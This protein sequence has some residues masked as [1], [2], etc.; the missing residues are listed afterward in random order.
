[1]DSR[2]SV[3]SFQ[4]DSSEAKGFQEAEEFP[5]L[6]VA[7]RIRA[8]QNKRAARERAALG[9]EVRYFMIV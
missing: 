4:P 9:I 2:Y 6:T 1:L 8:V 3:R 7:E 5:Q